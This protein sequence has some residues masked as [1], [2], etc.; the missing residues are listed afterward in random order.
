MKI[1][2]NEQPKSE[3]KRGR[4]DIIIDILEFAKK[5]TSKTA[6]VSGANLNF[7]LTEKYL[8]LL[9]KNGF[10]DNRQEKYVT[11]DKGKMFLEKAKEITLQL[12]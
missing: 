5:G 12:K 4:L 6:I 1:N 9:L 7:Q 8:A 3:N 2:K 10:M 11:T